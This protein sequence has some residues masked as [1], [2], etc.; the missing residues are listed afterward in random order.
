[1]FSWWTMVLGNVFLR[2]VVVA[3]GWSHQ[4]QFEEALKL[5]AVL[6]MDE[7][8]KKELLKELQFWEDEP[9]NSCP[10][11]GLTFAFKK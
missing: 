6:Y 2:D 1:M 11:E 8:K 10:A 5:P 9:D 3:E 4:T 7:E